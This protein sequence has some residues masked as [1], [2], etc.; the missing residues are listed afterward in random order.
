ML[1][2][3]SKI[4]VFGYYDGPTSGIVQCRLCTTVYKIETLDWDNM[5]DMR[6]CSL[7]LLQ[8]PYFNQLV[9]LLTPL[10][11]PTWPVWVPIWK[12]ESQEKE[13]ILN[14]Q[15]QEIVEKAGKV[16]L[17]IATENI[18]TEVLTAKKIT[19]EEFGSVKNWF[20][21]LDI[22]YMKEKQIDY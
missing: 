21:F 22:E 13:E 9:N 11:T 19:P 2:P 4:I 5:Q 15:V 6:I 18:A 1:S 3:F 12:F 16:S 17:V 7:A 20:S 10:G 14:R 8:T